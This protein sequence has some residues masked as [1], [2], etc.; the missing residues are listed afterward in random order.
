[1]SVPSVTVKNGL[2][3][4]LGRVHTA[5]VKILQKGIWT[6]KNI[7]TGVCALEHFGYVVLLQ[8]P[9]ASL[10]KQ[11]K[12]TSACGFPLNYLSH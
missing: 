7:K 2:G 6:P 10:D 11:Q 4:S 9:L 1:M 3:R 8:F 5:K 12:K